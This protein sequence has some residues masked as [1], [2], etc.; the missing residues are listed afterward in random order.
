MERR[1]DEEEIEFETRPTDVLIEAPAADA[2]P[3]AA[4]AQDDGKL[5]IEMWAERKEMLPQLVGT[6][7]NPH[8]WK[9]AAAKAFKG[10]AAGE[11]VS[12]EEFDAAV[13]EQDKQ[14]TR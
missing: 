7:P 14:I 11:R 1:T 5:P 9:F 13:D 12:E 3:S 8:Y 2:A 6:R 4:S 10:W